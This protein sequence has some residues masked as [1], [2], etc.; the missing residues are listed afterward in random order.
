MTLAHVAGLPIEESLATG[1]PALLA[2]LVAC[3]ARLRAFRT[4]RR[5]VRDG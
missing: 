5:R 1:G 2:A 3:G 4:R